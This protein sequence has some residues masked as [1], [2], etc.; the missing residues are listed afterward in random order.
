MTEESGRAKNFTRQELSDFIAAEV[1]ALLVRIDPAMKRAAV[2]TA[3]KLAGAVASSYSFLSHKRQGALNT[4]R[5]Q[6]EVQAAAF[7]AQIAMQ[8]RRAQLEGNNVE[9]DDPDLAEPSP[10]DNSVPEL[11]VTLDD[12]VGPAAGPT[13]LEK[14]FGIARS[15]LHRWQRRN[16]AIALLAGGRKH[17]FPL[18]QFVDGRPAPGIASVIDTI[19]HPRIAWRW[20]SRPSSALDG[21]LPIDLLKMD[22]VADVAAAVARYAETEG[23]RTSEALERQTG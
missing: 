22:R 14:N 6:M 4:Q 16:E 10:I 15:T 21:M 11:T 3:A 20:L 5:D 1:E 8:A 2:S 12:W 19:G 23:Q 18:A 13:F 9:T 17:V 7:V